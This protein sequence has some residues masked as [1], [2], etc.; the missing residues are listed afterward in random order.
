MTPAAWLE[1]GNAQT[2]GNDKRVG[3]QRKLEGVGQSSE[4]W[5]LV[6]VLRARGHHSGVS[7]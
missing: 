1:R 5:V 6:L 4:T 2:I 3:A 7:S